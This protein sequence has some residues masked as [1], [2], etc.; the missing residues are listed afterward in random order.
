MV[1]KNKMISS[2]VPDFVACLAPF[3]R[4]LE[5]SPT[6]MNGHMA[7]C[8]NLLGLHSKNRLNSVTLNVTRKPESAVR[9]SSICCVL[10]L[11]CRD[12]S[13]LTLRSAVQ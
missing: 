10:S 5:P 12:N 2:H 3:P 11:L 6:W 4:V 1:E 8:L 9:P 13:A 7:W